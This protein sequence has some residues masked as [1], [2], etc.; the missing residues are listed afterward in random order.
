MAQIAIVTI[1]MTISMLEKG[2]SDGTSRHIDGSKR[3]NDS[4]NDYN[5]SASEHNNDINNQRF[6]HLFHGY[7]QSCRRCG[8]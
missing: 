5:Y 7:D 8:H 1:Q 4:S 2:R 3:H 6:D